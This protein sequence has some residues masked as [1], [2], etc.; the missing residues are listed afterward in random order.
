M[1]TMQ[2]TCPKD[3]KSL[4][5]ESG[6]WIDWFQHM[7]D[8][9]K[10]AEDTVKECLDNC[11]EIGRIDMCEEGKPPAMVG[12]PLRNPECAFGRKALAKARLY[13]FNSLRGVIPGKIQKDIMDPISKLEL[14]WAESWNFQGVLYLHGKSGAGKSFCA[15]WLIYNRKIK[16]LMNYWDDEH[17]WKGIAS[18]TAWVSA[19]DAVDKTNME[20]L[21]K[22]PLLVLDDLGTEAQSPANKA[23]IGEII[24]KRYDNDV[25]TIIT[26]NLE[27]SSDD[28]SKYTCERLYGR[29]VVDR[30]AD[31]GKVVAFKGPSMRTSAA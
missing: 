31:S 8:M 6:S 2:N 24:S 19:Y 7:A 28:S 13:A 3:L 25:P 14:A 21:R 4:V 23:T 30:I 15:A 20:W 11:D 5:D 27:L 29:R 16:R 22:T 10:F 9:T 17:R 26:S 1:K 12:C 18:G